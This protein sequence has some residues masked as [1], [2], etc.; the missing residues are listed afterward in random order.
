MTH[1][2]TT[3]APMSEARR[4]HIH[5]PLVRPEGEPSLLAGVALLLGLC[6]LLVGIA[7]ALPA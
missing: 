4:Q 5:G 6:M 3:R 1:L 7:A 2:Y